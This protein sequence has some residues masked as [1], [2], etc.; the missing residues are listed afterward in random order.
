MIRTLF[1]AAFLVLAGAAMAQADD[2]LTLSGD[3]SQ[4]GLVFGK[5]ASGASVALNGKTLRTTADGRFIFGFGRD[6]AASATLTV[7]AADGGV[8]TRELEVAQREY[9]VQRIDGLPNRFVTPP[10]DVVARIRADAAAAAKARETDRSETDFDSGFRWPAIGIV[11]GVYGSQRVLNGEPRRPHFGIDIAAP[12]GTPV[13][14]PA[15]GVVTLV[16]PD[17]YFTGVTLF[18]DHGHGLS[19]AFLHLERVTVEEGQ[20][21]KQGEQ[22]ATVGSTGRSTGPHL[23]WRI[24]WF[25]ER[26]DPALLVPPMP[27]EAAAD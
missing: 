7:T 23:D 27:R 21:V 22:I 14:A 4:G 11:S 10:D 8:T 15:D 2:A 19:S 18:L 26:L 5:A 3:L 20:R 13:M 12:Q 25:A 17:M 1:T 16:H 9:R 24:N 6:A